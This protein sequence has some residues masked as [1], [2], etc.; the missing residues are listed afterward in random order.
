MRWAAT[1][2]SLGD[3]FARSRAARGGRPGGGNDRLRSPPDQRHGRAARPRRG[4]ARVRVPARRRARL[5]HVGVVGRCAGGGGAL[6]DALPLPG[7]LGH[8]VRQPGAD[9]PAAGGPRRRAGGRR[10]GCRAGLGARAGSVALRRLGGRRRRGAARRTVRPL[11]HGIGAGSRPRGVRAPELPTRRA[12]RPGRP[13][14]LGAG[15]GV[16]CCARLAARAHQRNRAAGTAAGGESPRRG[17][18]SSAA[19]PPPHLSLAQASRYG[20]SSTGADGARGKTSRY[21]ESR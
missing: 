10:A 16:R 20:D 17:E 11:A 7:P 1:T 12:G 8:R 15:H 13:P 4:A 19:W 18:R 9:L 14:G 2:L 6:V 5:R 3:Y 21:G